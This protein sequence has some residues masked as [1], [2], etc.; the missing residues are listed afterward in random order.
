[1]AV[2]PFCRETSHCLLA[3]IKDFSGMDMLLRHSHSTSSLSSRSFRSVRLQSKCCCP[4]HC[5]LLSGPRT[6]RMSLTRCCSSPSSK[7]RLVWTVTSIY[8]P[9][10]LAV[11]TTKSI[12]ARCVWCFGIAS[13]DAVRKWFFSLESHVF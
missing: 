8:S 12:V 4:L 2:S 6:Q 10:G 7:G 9:F 5:W 3:F 11:K 13:S 1:M